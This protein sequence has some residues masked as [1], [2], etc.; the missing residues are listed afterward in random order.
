VLYSKFPKKIFI[1]NRA[2]LMS[3]VTECYRFK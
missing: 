3:F 2:N 1:S